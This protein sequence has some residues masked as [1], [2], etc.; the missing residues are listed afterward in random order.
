MLAALLQARAGRLL[1]PGLLAKQN[2]CASHVAALTGWRL[3]VRR[4]QGR[5]SRCRWA[6]L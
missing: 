1:L 3:P 6:S 2:S 5:E 4:L